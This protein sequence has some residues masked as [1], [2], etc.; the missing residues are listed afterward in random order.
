MSR[1]DLIA[2]FEISDVHPSPAMFDTKKLDWM[3]GEYIRLLDANELTSLVTRF[4]VK[5][6]LVGEQPSEEE[7]EKIAAATP[8]IQTRIRRLDEAPGLVAGLFK[9][10]EVDPAAAAKAM[11]GDHVPDLFERTLQALATVEPWDKENV[12]AALRSI[13]EEMGLKPRTA[14]APFYAAISGSTVSAPVFDLMTLIGRTECLARLEHGLQ[15]SRRLA[16]A[17][18]P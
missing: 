10:P 15:L 17:V 5:A 3:N 14:F 4:Y 12:E 11:S 6:G 8:L 1:D 2:R 7:S 9:R 18:T 13:A 16:S